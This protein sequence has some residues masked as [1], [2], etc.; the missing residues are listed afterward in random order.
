M[1][2]NLQ[3]RKKVSQVS[4][5][6]KAVSQQRIVGNNNYGDWESSESRER[7]CFFM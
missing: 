1:M 2:G 6:S 7:L 5:A 3:R 4:L